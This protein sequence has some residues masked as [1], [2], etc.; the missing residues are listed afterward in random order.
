MTSHSASASQSRLLRGAAEVGGGLDQREERVGPC[1]WPGALHPVG[2]AVLLHTQLGA[3]GGTEET[4]CTRGSGRGWE[5]G[6]HGQRLFSGS[7]RTAA[8]ES[9]DWV[10]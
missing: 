5:F 7:P 8:L 9:D 10:P 3:R 1:S 4:D 2:I 6:F